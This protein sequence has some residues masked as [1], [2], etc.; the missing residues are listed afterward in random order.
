[1]ENE[2]L[3]TN[4]L[5]LGAKNDIFVGFQRTVYCEAAKMLL[6]HKQW[7]SWRCSTVGH[8]QTA[9]TRSVSAAQ[10]KGKQL[11]T[12][13][14]VPTYNLGQENGKPGKSPAWNGKNVFTGMESWPSHEAHNQNDKV[15]TLQTDCFSRCPPSSGNAVVHELIVTMRG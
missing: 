7:H 15:F 4:D 12:S 5:S 13:G 6:L 1:M 3:G 11:L 9:S 10:R 14:C 8:M 2:G